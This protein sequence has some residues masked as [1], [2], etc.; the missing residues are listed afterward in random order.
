MEW[1]REGPGSR[2]DPPLGG[3]RAN[4]SGIITAPPPSGDR[5]VDSQDGAPFLPPMLNWGRSGRATWAGVGVG[6]VK[7]KTPRLGPVSGAVNGAI[8]P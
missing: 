2:R 7:K 5:P 4:I 1:G 6:N 8:A 3:S